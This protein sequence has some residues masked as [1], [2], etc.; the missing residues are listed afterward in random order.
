VSV[1]FDSYK[2]SD[3]TT[4]ALLREIKGGVKRSAE[5]GADSKSK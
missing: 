3:V 5:D 4:L 2:N 1:V